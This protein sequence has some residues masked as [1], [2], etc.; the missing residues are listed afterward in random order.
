MGRSQIIREEAEREKRRMQGIYNKQV[1]EY[2]AILER[3]LVNEKDEEANELIF[4]ILNNSVVKTS[5]IHT[6]Y[7][8]N[9]VEE[10][11]NL[12]LTIYSG[13][14]PGEPP[15][16]EF[17]DIKLNTKNGRIEIYISSCFS[18]TCEYSGYINP[19]A[20]RKIEEIICDR[21]RISKKTILID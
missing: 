7:N 15:S 12:E 20:S 6:D 13:N 1:E 11:V 3:L 8:G 16:T 10:I 17:E 4:K 21:L 14:I 5:K 19:L 2:N 18:C 9:L